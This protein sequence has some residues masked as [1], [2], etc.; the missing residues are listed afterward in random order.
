MIDLANTKHI[1]VHGFIN[2]P[3]NLGQE[4]C[5][6]N[7]PAV[8]GHTVYLRVPSDDGYDIEEEADFRTMDAARSYAKQLATKH[9][10]LHIEVE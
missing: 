2:L 10:G 1:V 3:N 4:W 8:E 6:N 5:W 7:D 9:G